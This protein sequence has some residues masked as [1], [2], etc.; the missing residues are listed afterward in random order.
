MRAQLHRTLTELVHNGHF[1]GDSQT[2]DL[3]IRHDRVWRI[4][5]ATALHTL[6][7]API[8][9][10]LGALGALARDVGFDA[11]GGLDIGFEALCCEL[12]R[13]KG[14]VREL[15]RGSVEIVFREFHRE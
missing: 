2:V 7:R 10:L 5:S 1:L 3:S 9:G 15:R 6:T 8:F 12:L 4:C 11:F 13:G 14:P